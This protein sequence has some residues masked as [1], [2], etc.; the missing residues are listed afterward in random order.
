MNGNHAVEHAKLSSQMSGFRNFCEQKTGQ[1]FTYDEFHAFSVREFRTFWS[2]FLEWCGVDWEGTPEP[3]CTDDRCEFAFFFPN[4]RMSYPENV[5]RISSKQDGERTAI[6]TCNAFGVL[7]RLTRSTLRLQVIRLSRELERLGVSAGD[8]VVSVVRNRSESVVGALASAAI[9]ATFSSA[10]PEMGTTAILSRFRQLEP[11]VLMMHTALSGRTDE[12]AIMQK[13]SEI[14]LGLPSL[15]VLVVLDDG[16]LPESFDG[17]IVRFSEISKDSSGLDENTF[18]WQRFAFNHPLFILFTSGTTGLPKCLVHGAGG[19]LLE[20]IKEHRL[21]EDLRPSD[22]L[23]FYTTTAWMMWNWQLSAL[24]SGCE[25]V[26]YDDGLSSPDDFW[27]TVAAEEVSVLGTSPSF[28]KLCEDAKYSPRDALSF[29]F[30]RLIQSTGSVLDEHQ[31][32]WVRRHIGDIPVHS[33][34]GG[35][36]IVGCFVLG[37]PDLPVRPGESQCRSLGLDVQAFQLG[38]PA[39]SGSV[40]DLVCCNPFPSRPLGFF[41]DDGAR[42][43]DAYFRQNEGVWT[44]G[45]R[46]TFSEAGGARIHGR[47]DSTINVNGL[48]IGPAEIYRV[49]ASIPEVSEAM[50][51]E[52]RTPGRGTSSR[53]VLLIVPRRRGTVDGP[54]RRTIRKLLAREA[55]PAHV[56]SLIVEVGA[57]PVTY[58]GK[59]SETAA[60]DCL[61]DAEA[62]NQ[63]ALANPDCLTDIRCAVER[64]DARKAADA[65]RPDATIEDMIR[66]IWETTLQMSDVDPDDNFFELGGTSL[67]AIRICQ[68]ISDKLSITIGPWI[69][70]QAP[71]MRALVTELQR[72]TSGVASPVIRLRPQGSDTPIFL[73]PGMYGDVIELRALVSA[74]PCDWPVYGVRCRGL[75]PGERAH[76][77]VQDMAYDYLRYLRDIQPAGP[78]RLAGYSF[79]G[80]VAWEVA[81]LLRRANEKVAFLGLIDAQV[82]ERSLA[83]PKR[84]A[85]QAKRA[86][87]R[88]ALCLRQPR[89]QISNLI[90]PYANLSPFIH[91][92]SSQN[93]PHLMKQLGRINSRA[94]SRYRP[95]CYDSP[96]TFFEARTRWHGFCDPLLVWNRLCTGSL[97]VCEIDGGHTDQMCEPYVSKL[98]QKLAFHVE[99]SV[100]L[101]VNGPHEVVRNPA[102]FVARIGWLAP[103]NGWRRRTP[104]SVTQDLHRAVQGQCPSPSPHPKA[105]A[106]GHELARV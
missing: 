77:R 104:P 36:D 34:S 62:V 20:H 52:Q 13:L 60:R 90:E 55:S 9:G 88:A 25:I 6:T 50:A 53:I 100:A 32:E 15:N 94:F 39:P 28:L 69:L 93:I 1:T 92:E 49:L 57:L 35:T 5:L 70:F 98:A 18:R 99:R 43:H 21:H 65:L 74:M 56:P 54:M 73:F 87:H 103:G 23:F 8:R 12:V 72:D 78:Y 33:I 80:L 101:E 79:G 11:K 96:V 27:R 68:A 102:E 59:R 86:L 4:V 67:T 3:V 84:W 24:A 7:E 42:F 83:L 2:F 17:A 85:F 71:T 44:H 89:V 61:N 82:H 58:T 63:G 66:R 29:P 14:V 75:A 47:S 31:Y 64:V 38:V 41:G 30:L 40:G 26:L 46:I 37:H 19:T 76:A 97:E 91:I 16:P 81:C 10:A 106:Q 105:A 95:K 51:V 22:K 45:D 48:R